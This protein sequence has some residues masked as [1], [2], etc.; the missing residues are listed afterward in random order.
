MQ[1][2]GPRK[3]QLTHGTSTAYIQHRCRCDECVQAHRKRTK[4]WRARRQSGAVHYVDAQPLKDHVQ[5]LLESGMSFSAIA[6]AAGWASRNSLATALSHGKVTPRTMQRVLAITPQSDDRQKRYVDATGARR[7]L[8]A[9]AAMGW[10]ARC[11]AKHAGHS[12][13]DTYVDIANGSLQRIR[14]STADEIKS[15]YD[16]LWDKAGPSVRSKERARRLGYAVPMA[17]DDDSIDDPQAQPA[18]RRDDRQDYCIEDITELLDQGHTK[19]AVAMRFGI[20]VN[21]LEAAL[22]RH[23]KRRKHEGT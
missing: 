2:A 14:A 9:L 7:R 15:L 21:A 23:R 17:W 13:H 10:T 6:H 8:Q 12:A 20:K 3:G 4:R 16:R 22:S 18:P 19:P 1:P 5:A 11:F